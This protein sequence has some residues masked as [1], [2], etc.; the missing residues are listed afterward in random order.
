MKKLMLIIGLMFSAAA[1]AEGVTPPKSPPVTYD[2]PTVSIVQTDAP[3]N[4]NA[5]AR[6]D[7]LAIAEQTQ[8]A[9]NEG[10][11]TTV[12]NVNPR[13]AP[14]VGQG[15]FAIQGCGVAGNAGGSNTN[16]A[17]FLGI[18]FTPAQCYDFQL[19]QAYQSLGAYRAACEV[20]NKSRAGRRAEK[21]GVELPVCYAPDPVTPP[22]P[23]TVVIEKPAECPAC[24]DC[25]KAF[26]QC[27]A[28]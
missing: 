23:T 27:V 4:A 20:L 19:A 3:N 28:K 15:S 25:D 5:N 12:T 8:Q 21:R 1:L 14:A 17:A 10:V 13:Q 9:V 11:K 24:P 22:V 7:S 6:A 2:P 26:K 16:G 18:A